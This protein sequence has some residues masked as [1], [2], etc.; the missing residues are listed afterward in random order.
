MGADESEPNQVGHDLAD[1][2]FPLIDTHPKQRFWWPGDSVGLDL[3]VKS[4]GSQYSNV[5]NEL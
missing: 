4:T 2:F 5:E 1:E 3:V